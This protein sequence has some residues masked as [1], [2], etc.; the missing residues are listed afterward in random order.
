MIS[1]ISR[2]ERVY[3]VDFRGG[4]VLEY[5]LNPPPH[6]NKV[7]KILRDKGIKDVVIQ[8]FK[9]IKGGVIIKSKNDITRKVEKVLGDN[10]SQVDRL[11]VTT[12]GPAVGTILRKK[13]LWAISFSLL[14]ILIYITLRFKHFDFALAGVIALFHDVLVSL[15]FLSLLGFEVDLLTITAL[16]TIAG[17]SINDTIVV[18]DRIREIG[19]RLFKFSL[20]EII[21]RAINQTL[22]RTIITSFTTILVVV[23]M[24][25][26]GGKALRGF[27]FTLL[28]GFIA[29]TYSSIYIASPL[30]LLF[31]KSQPSLK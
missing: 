28:V 5:K 1:F 17:Y 6:I 4:Q 14:G 11:K 8:E 19:P 22:P 16:L 27:S 26:L 10:F 7:R 20:R 3:G 25:L 15:G 29:G 24:Y 23:S 2:G 18:Y 31:R 21:N 9:D 30:V 13:A 12:V